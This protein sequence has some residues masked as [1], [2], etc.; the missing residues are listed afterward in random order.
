MTEPTVL[1]LIADAQNEL[2]RGEVRGSLATIAQ[3][4][5][6]LDELERQIAERRLVWN[7]DH[8]GDVA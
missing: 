5:T 8:R 7:D 3:I 4:R 6:I 1:R 2:T